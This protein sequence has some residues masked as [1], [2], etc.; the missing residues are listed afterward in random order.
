MFRKTTVFIVGF[1]GPQYFGFAT[2]VTWEVELY[3]DSVYGPLPAPA[4]GV[5]SHDSALSVLAASAASVPP[6][7]LTSLELTTPVDGFARIAG[8]APF[9]VFECM[10]TVYLPFAPT[11]TPSRRNAGLPLR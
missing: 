5:F 6:C 10:T 1:F 11:V 3:A 7:C 2:S 4:P 8:S 9:G